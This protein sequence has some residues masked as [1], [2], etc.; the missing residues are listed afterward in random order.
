MNA[1]PSLGGFSPM[2]S[3]AARAFMVWQ[4]HDMML[5]GGAAWAGGQRIVKSK[6]NEE[7]N[8][9]QG[10]VRVTPEKF[11][12]KEAMDDYI[13][14]QR[15]GLI[16]TTADGLWQLMEPYLKASQEYFRKELEK[17][18]TMQEKVMEKSFD[19]EM[20]K[21]QYNYKLLKEL[22]KEY[23]GL[24]AQ[25]LEDLARGGK[26]P[27]TAEIP[28]NEGERE[29]IAEEIRKRKEEA[30][31]STPTPTPTPTPTVNR[32]TLVVRYNTWRIK[33][34]LVKKTLVTSTHT[35]T[36]EQLNNT[37]YSMTTA[38]KNAL[39]MSQRSKMQSQR[40]KWR[41][42]AQTKS[43]QLAAF[44]KA[45]KAKFKRNIVHPNSF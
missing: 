31:K 23:F 8:S 37:G 15:E 2:P 28:Y 44:H 17:S 5:V 10:H 12:T 3:N 29:R 13:K 20:M 40:E 1:L 39:Q 32:H 26:D 43:S 11:P 6:S 14:K 9:L 34:G 35:G 18:N 22:P 21:A 4:T 33:N 38:I 7:W 27:A 25:D 30:Q 16:K 19:L 36:Q 24:I 42:V 41:L 45:Y